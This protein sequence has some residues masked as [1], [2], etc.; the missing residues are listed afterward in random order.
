MTGKEKKKADSDQSKETSVQDS[1]KKK[2]K[3]SGQEDIDL[4]KLTPIL[5]AAKNGITEMVETILV[6]YPMAMYDVDKNQK[7]IVLLTA[8]HKQPCVY[9][10]LLSLK[11]KKLIKESIF[12]EVDN[13]GNSAL[14]LA[15]KSIDFSWPV[16]GALSQMQ[17]EI[18]WYEVRA[19]NGQAKEDFY[20]SLILP[21]LY[22]GKY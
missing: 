3:R 4:T 8:E 16:P 22:I 14:H 15:A 21:I 11:E 19:Q 10:L 20:L 18:K 13:E 17:W 12:G 2:K 7:N 1:T 5:V 6:N 9:E